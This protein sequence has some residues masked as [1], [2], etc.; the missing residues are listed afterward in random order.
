VLPFSQ[1]AFMLILGSDSYLQ[2]SRWNMHKPVA[3]VLLFVTLPLLSDAQTPQPKPV[4]S[5]KTKTAT[6]AAKPPDPALKVLYADL[7]IGEL[8][9]EDANRWSDK[10]SSRVAVG[11]FITDISK[12][13]E[14]DTAVRICENP[15]IDGMDRARC[16]VAKCIPKLPC[17]LPTVGK[18]VTVKGITRYDAKVGSHWWEIEPI[19]VVDK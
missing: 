16:I 12:S 5:K 13:E 17:D 6:P 2:T 8:V 11:G 1:R 3:I 18:P 19:E 14:G 15:K 4:S 9:N 10:M 7:T